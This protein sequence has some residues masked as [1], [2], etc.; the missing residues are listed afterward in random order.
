MTDRPD[1]LI[2]TAFLRPG[3]D[4][5][6]MLRDAGLVTAH[7][8]D[9]D[10]LS[11]VERR[12]LLGARAIIAGTKPLGSEEFALADRLRVIVRT[13]VG[14]D[15]IDLDAAARQ[16]IAVCVTPGANRQAVAEHVFA[17]MLASARRIPENVADLARGQW[18]QL[19]G[20]QLSGAT[21]GILGLGSIGKAV[22]RIG[23]GFG[24][25]IVAFDPYFDVEF[26]RAHGVMQVDLD[27]LFRQSD[28]ITLHL[29]LDDST[30]NLIDAT[31]LAQMK[32]DA[33]LINTA[34]GGILDEDAVITAVRE[35]RIG[36][37]AIDVFA[38]EPLDS[39]SPMLHTPGILA[40][41]HIA[42][43]TREAR[44]ASGTMAAQN[45]ITVLAGGEPEFVVNADLAG[46]RS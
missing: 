20:R 35:Q 36:G 39:D 19:T 37:A 38:S 5:D 7:A 4:V 26:A 21:L 33:V 32:S 24:M 29:F 17:L 46:V 9:L 28:F 8:P 16:G 25:K 15:S 42:G 44:G 6:R 45:V 34:R 27:D 14:Y 2:T 13:G 41:S 3:D 43:A 11:G 18:N 31:R 12:R 23:E 1:V 40:T 10:A 22:A 30:R